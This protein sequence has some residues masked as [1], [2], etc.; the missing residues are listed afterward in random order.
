[1]SSTRGHNAN[2]FIR[3]LPSP[4]SEQIRHEYIFYR[5]N[6]PP[7][8]NHSSA[9]TLGNPPGMNLAP[10][11]C[12]TYHVEPN[13]IPVSDMAEQRLAQRCAELHDQF[14]ARR[15]KEKVQQQKGKVK[16]VKSRGG[17]VGVET[18]FAKG[19][20]EIQRKEG[21]EGMGTR[22]EDGE[23]SGGESTASY[24]TDE[25]NMRPNAPTQTVSTPMPEPKTCPARHEI[26]T[27][28]GSVVGAEDWMAGF[29]NWDPAN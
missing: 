14:L 13:L 25:G 11:D 2:A 7:L 8:Y 9:P 12:R 26:S 23:M 3:S 20:M 18:G 17:A 1:M 16:M 22:D 5:D 28:T 21:H 15:L 4:T 6:Q 10:G 19:M 27:L 29:V 24:S